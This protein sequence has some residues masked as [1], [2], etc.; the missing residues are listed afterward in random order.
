MTLKMFLDELLSKLI[1]LIL[2]IFIFIINYYIIIC[3]RINY[4]YYF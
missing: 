2:G 1:L 4:Y 3:T